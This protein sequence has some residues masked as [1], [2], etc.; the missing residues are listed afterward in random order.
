MS[1][2]SQHMAHSYF[3]CSVRDD[4]PLAKNVAAAAD[5]ALIALMVSS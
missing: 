3:S 1:Y 5:A 2:Y 4:L